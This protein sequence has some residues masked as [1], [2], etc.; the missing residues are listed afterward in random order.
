MCWIA[1]V[2]FINMA[3]LM[4]STMT[5]RNVATIL[6]DIS[7][8]WAAECLSPLLIINA[9]PL[10]WWWW[11][12]GTHTSIWLTE[13]RGLKELLGQEIFSNDVPVTL[14]MIFDTWCRSWWYEL[15]S[16]YE[17]PPLTRK[18]K[19]GGGM[20]FVQYLNRKHV[21]YKGSAL[22]CDDDGLFCRFFQ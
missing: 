19:R 3:I 15:I 7:E 14:C 5:A 1:G 4:I 8:Y 21:F 12:R 2:Y 6:L 18:P 16:K 11:G 22:G 13:N 10:C 20:L 17:V 9:P